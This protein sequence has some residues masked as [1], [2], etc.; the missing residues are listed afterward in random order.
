MTFS[1]ADVDGLLLDIDGVLAISWQPITGSVE[2]MRWIRQRGL[3]FRLITNTTTH[4]RSDLAATL[5]SAGFDV[6][7]E[8]IVTAVVATVTHLKAEHPDAPVYVLS[9][10]DAR[11]DLEGVRLVDDPED[12]EVIVIGG[13]CDDFSYDTLNRCFRRVMDGAAL[14]GMHRNLYWRTA[15]G[16]QLDGGAFLAGIEEA[17]GVRAAVC[18]KPSPDYFTSVLALLG[19]SADRSLM[20]GDDIVNDVNGAQAAGIRAVLVRTGK[21]QGS[22]LSKGS[23]DAVVDALDALP[24]ILGG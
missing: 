10:G 13:A 5:G 23:P 11:D 19:T 14:V 4:T 18:G 12:A 6:A 8:E 16:W 2:A 22:D 3:P 24:G 17:A 9:D 7:P 1:L 20:V 15:E 21:F